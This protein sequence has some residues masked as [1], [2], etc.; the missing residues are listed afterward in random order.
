MLPAQI[1]DMPTVDMV[2]SAIAMAK[3]CRVEDDTNPGVELGL[4]MARNALRGRDKVT[5]AMS[6]SLERFGL[7]LEQL[8]A[9]STGKNNRGL[10]PV[11]DEPLIAPDSYGQDR[12]FIR[13]AIDGESIPENRAF[14]NHP[15]YDIEVPDRTAIAG[16]FFRWEF[17]TAVAA[18]GIGVYPFD[19]PDVRISQATR[20]QGT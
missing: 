1:C 17:A 20:A 13:I 12:Q 3:R 15:T 19:Q 2:R 5:F 10:I 6:P 14:D 9:E 16:E 7:W 4:F 8:L 18:C 11:A